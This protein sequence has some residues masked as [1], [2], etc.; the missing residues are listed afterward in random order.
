MRA[1]KN[2][3]RDIEGNIREAREKIAKAYQMMDSNRPYADWQKDMAMQHLTFN[4]KGYEIVKKMIAD[5]AAS[6]DPL[7]PGMR[8]M[9]E[10]MHADMMRDTAEVKAMIDNYGK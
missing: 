4:T 5:V 7:A 9:F 8:A 6:T 1:I 2:V 3:T 10:D